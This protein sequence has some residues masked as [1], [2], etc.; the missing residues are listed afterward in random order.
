MS[1][2]DE[3]RHVRMVYRLV[4]AGMGVEVTDRPFVV[5]TTPAADC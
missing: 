4:G 5:A 3:R 2:D 1:D